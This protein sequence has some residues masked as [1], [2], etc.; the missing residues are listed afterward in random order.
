LRI[1][2]G[3]IVFVA[4][5]MLYLFGYRVTAPP[6]PAPLAPSSSTCPPPPDTPAPT[7][8]A[9]SGGGA[10]VVARPVRGWP[11]PAVIS[12]MTITAVPADQ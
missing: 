7:T 4:L 10:G 6:D 11:C 9:P 3:L 2:I 8:T 12:T 1:I 5:C